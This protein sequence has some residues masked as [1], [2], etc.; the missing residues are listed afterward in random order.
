MNRLQP[1]KHRLPRF[2]PLGWSALPIDLEEAWPWS[3]DSY[4][5]G[6]VVG[7]CN[8]SMRPDRQANVLPYACSAGYT[9]S[10]FYGRTPIDHRALTITGWLHSWYRSMALLFLYFSWASNPTE[11]ISTSSKASRESR[12]NDIDSYFWTTLSSTTIVTSVLAYAIFHL[13]GRNGW[14]AW[15]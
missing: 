1:G 9:W 5:N 12:I 11:V 14:E 10:K 6:S 8:V 7:S 4:S 3:L 13:E 15:R 2:L